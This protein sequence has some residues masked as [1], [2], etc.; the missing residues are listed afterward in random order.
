[1]AGAARR[2]PVEHRFLG[3]DRR[4]FPYALAAVAVWF[5]WTVLAP[6]V[7]S[8]VPWDDTTRAGERIRLTDTVTFAPAAGWGLESGLRTTDITKSGQT[9]TDVELTSDGVTFYVQRGPWRGSARQLLDQITKITSTT[10]GKE[11]FALSTSPVGFQTRSGHDGV[12]EQFRS[13]RVE[14]LLAALV[15]GAEGLRVQAVG[16]PEQLA[17]HADEIGQ[18]L[19]SIREDRR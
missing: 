2:V 10:S 12:L 7:D 11:G 17:G 15:F 8:R 5:V 13:T 4:T 1:M 3:L 9:A 18:M 19:A 6:W 16:P 14:G